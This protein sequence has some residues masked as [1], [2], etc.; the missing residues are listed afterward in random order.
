MSLAMQSSM[1]LFCVFSFVFLRFISKTLVLQ[2]QSGLSTE[3]TI[4]PEANS[5]Q[6]GVVVVDLHHNKIWKIK[7]LL[8]MFSSFLVL[9]LQLMTI[10][11]TLL[12]I[13]I[14]QHQLDT[15]I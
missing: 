9:F 4:L 11:V 14:V 10:N 2:C 15:P 6:T 12:L 8:P 1:S 13:C 3:V 5:G 7:T